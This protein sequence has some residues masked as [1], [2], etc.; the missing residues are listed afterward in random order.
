MQPETNPAIIVGRTQK[1]LC[2][3]AKKLIIRRLHSSKQ[4]D[5]ILKKSAAFLQRG[6][7]PEMFQELSLA[8]LRELEEVSNIM[9]CVTTAN[10]KYS[11]FLSNILFY[12][13]D[14][15]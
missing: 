13:K 5:K 2:T 1:A 3:S 9:D 11:I 6:H 7:K 12:V 8:G 10:I 14:T 15:S 4:K